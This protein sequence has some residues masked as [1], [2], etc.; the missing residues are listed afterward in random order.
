VPSFEQD[1]LVFYN[2]ESHYEVGATPLILLWKDQ[3]TSSCA[4]EPWP[5]P[6]PSYPEKSETPLSVVLELKKDGKLY[7]HDD[8]PIALGALSDEMKQSGTVQEFES[9]DLLRFVVLDTLAVLSCGEENVP[10]HLGLE[11]VG[12]A[13]ASRGQADSFS[14]LIF[15]CRVRHDP[16]TLEMI[17]ESA[18]NPV[19][20]D[21][22]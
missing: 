12:R 8:P 16:L 22:E 10:Q 21:H 9:G 14:R 3:A 2:R 20:M 11:L 4:V 5:D 7:S 15:Q 19:G 13:G 1:G 6:G 18:D 17:L